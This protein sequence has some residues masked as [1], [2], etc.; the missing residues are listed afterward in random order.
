MTD[1]SMQG[2]V[3]HVLGVLWLNP[4]TVLGGQL[5]ANQRVVAIPGAKLEDGDIIVDPAGLR[6]ISENTPQKSIQAS[7]AIYGFLKIKKP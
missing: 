6:H 7:G 1:E 2:L 4:F 5:Q 3:D